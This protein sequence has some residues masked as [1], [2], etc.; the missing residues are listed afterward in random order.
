M[1]KEILFMPFFKWSL[2]FHFIW[3]MIYR[4]LNFWYSR[5]WGQ[6]RV[7]VTVVWWGSC[8][9]TH[10]SL[11]PWLLLPQSSINHWSPS[12]GSV[13]LHLFTLFIGCTLISLGSFAKETCTILLNY[14]FCFD[15]SSRL[16]IDE[17]KNNFLKTYI[18]Y[19]LSNSFLVP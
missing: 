3:S 7:K 1:I 2:Y 14:Y 10:W 18:A 19:F 17:C 11:K 15:I 13:I 12:L 8:P 5:L 4:G 6:V 16:S 9:S